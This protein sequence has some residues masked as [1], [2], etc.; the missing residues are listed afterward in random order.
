MAI[1]TQIIRWLDLNARTLKLTITWTSDGSGDV[2]EAISEANMKILIGKNLAHFIT[3]PGAIAPTDDYD[4][5]LLD[6]YGVD[7]LGGEGADRDTAN[8]EQGIPA[9]KTGIYGDR[10]IDSAL[11]FTIAA[12]GD[13]KQGTVILYLRW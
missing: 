10:I 5:T 8:S 2:S 6:A 12:A 4:F 11:T 1:D 13:T 3:D 9:I 7:V